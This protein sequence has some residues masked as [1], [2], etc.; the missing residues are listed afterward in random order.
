MRPD[1]MSE[2]PE[3]AAITIMIMSVLGVNMVVLGSIMTVLAAADG[4]AHACQHAR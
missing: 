1:R 3:K 2:S 4:V